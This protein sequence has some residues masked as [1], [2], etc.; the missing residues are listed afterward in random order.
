MA[1]YFTR[2]VVKQSLTPRASDDWWPTGNSWH[3]PTVSD[4]DATDTGLIDAN[5]DPIMRA[6]NP[7]GFGRD[8]EW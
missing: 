1:R 4:H 5:G 7:I 2:P 6:P 3:I 8:E